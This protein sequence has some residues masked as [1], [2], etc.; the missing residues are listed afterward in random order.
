MIEPRQEEPS[1]PISLP[2]SAR[3]YIDEQ[4]ANG[5]YSSAD[6]MLADLV[7]QAQESHAKTKVNHLLKAALQNSE[8]VEATDEWWDQQRAKFAPKHLSS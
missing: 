7:A 6:S 2:D 3:A 8:T 4:V 5:H 1:C